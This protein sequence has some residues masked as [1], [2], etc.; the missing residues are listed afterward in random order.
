MDIS[1]V[2][3]LTLGLGRQGGSLAPK[4][5]KNLCSKPGLTP[6][7]FGLDTLTWLLESQ[8]PHCKTGI[9]IPKFQYKNEMR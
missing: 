5:Q 1:R 4:N 8:F 3:L 2:F 9:M 7:L 6:H